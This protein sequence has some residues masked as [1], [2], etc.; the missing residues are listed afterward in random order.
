VK[1]ITLRTSLKCMNL[2]LYDEES[3][4]LIGYKKLKEIRRDREARLKKAA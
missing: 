4:Q 2:R 1:P 3:R